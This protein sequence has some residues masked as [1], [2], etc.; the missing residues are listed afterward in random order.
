M[1]GCFFPVIAQGDDEPAVLFEQANIAQ[2]QGDYAQAIAQYLT[3][4]RHGVSAS[5]LYNLANSYAVSGQIG[6]AVLNY[7]RALRLAPGN[8]DILANLKQ[9]RKEA[10][11]YR[12]DR[13]LYICLAVLLGPD[14]WLLLFA[15]TL[16]LLAGT[17]LA[18]SLV[19]ER[20]WGDVLRLAMI[21]SLVLMLLTLP[22]TLL[23][24]RSWNDGVVLEEDR[25]LISP[26]AEAASA[27][28][29]KAGQLVR[30]VRKHGEYVL[31]EDESGKSG[32]LEQGNLQRIAELI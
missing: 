13:P 26:F 9:V 21:G 6:L 23:G 32:W 7:E 24:Y 19:K 25:L 5:L 4:S 1:F 2:T 11:L 28:N 27:S 17:A 10:G 30:P 18:A 3:I 22:P 29:I 12:Q 20:R 16:L 31:V 14:Q 15:V 8:P